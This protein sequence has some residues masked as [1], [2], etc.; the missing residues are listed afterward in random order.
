MF[1]IHVEWTLK[2]KVAPTQENKRDSGLR[3]VYNN[4]PKLFHACFFQKLANEC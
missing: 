2:K 3:N 1:H 4:F